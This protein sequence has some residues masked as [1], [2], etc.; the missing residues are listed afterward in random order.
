MIML[1]ITELEIKIDYEK[2]VKVQWKT[3]KEMRDAN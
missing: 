1:E 3:L 2:L